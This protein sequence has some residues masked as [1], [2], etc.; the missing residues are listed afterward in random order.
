MLP[1]VLI[2]MGLIITYSIPNAVILNKVLTGTVGILLIGYIIVQI[3]FVLRMLKAS[4]YSID[5]SLEEAAKNLGASNIRTFFKVLLP[6]ILPS[7]LALVAL[8]FNSTLDEYTFIDV[9]KSSILSTIRNYHSKQYITRNVTGY[10]SI[11]LCIHSYINGNFK[12]CSLP[13]LWSRNK[14]RQI[15]KGNY[16]CG[17]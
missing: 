2:A 12:Y 6:I 8:T 16:I 3:P 15:T 9:F 10:K 7:A 17:N 14:G 4:F 5:T 1:S 13:C 11:N